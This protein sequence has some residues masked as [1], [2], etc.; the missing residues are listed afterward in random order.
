MPRTPTRP[1]SITFVAIVLIVLGCLSLLGAIQ[2]VTLAIVALS[3]EPAPATRAPGQPPDQ[4]SI[5]R[6][7]AKEVPGYYPVA[8]AAESLNVLFGLA[9][10]LCGVGLLKLKPG[11]RIWALWLI[12]AKLL[13]AFASNAYQGFVVIPPTQRFLAENIVQPAG[14]QAPADLIST[15]TGAILI[16]VVVGSVV[17][18]IAVAL[19]LILV[20]TSATAKKAFSGGAEPQSEEGEPKEERPRSRYEGYDEDDDLPPQ[21]PPETGITDRS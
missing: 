2:I 17:F 11:A 5:H 14:Q 1:G 4:A 12:I 20:L 18:Q 10:L 7:L 16:M 8:F 15:I 19:T 3:A 21:A 9:Q 6:F 13:F